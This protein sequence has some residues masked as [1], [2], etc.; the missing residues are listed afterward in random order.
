MFSLTDYLIGA[1]VFCAVVAVLLTW[2]EWA[3]D[4]KKDTP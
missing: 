1:S 3:D 2:V 4:N